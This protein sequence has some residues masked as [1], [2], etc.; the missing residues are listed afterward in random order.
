MVGLRWRSS[1]LEEGL[2]V[3]VCCFKPASSRVLEYLFCLLSFP[4]PFPITWCETYSKIVLLV[5]TLWLCRFLS[6]TK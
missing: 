1:E 4:K 6:H 5:E 3:A 2:S